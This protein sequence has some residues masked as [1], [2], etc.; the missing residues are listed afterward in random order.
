MP[1]LVSSAAAAAV[2]V[3][4]GTAAAIVGLVHTWG[5]ADQACG[6]QNS[7]FLIPGREGL[8]LRTNLLRELPAN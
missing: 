4:A 1:A 6:L 3:A 5:T 2:A 7:Q 8:I